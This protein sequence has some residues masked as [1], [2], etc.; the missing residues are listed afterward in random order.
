[1]KKSFIYFIFLLASLQGLTAYALPVLSS[2]PAAAATIYLDFDGETVNSSVWQS[3]NPFTCAPANMTD[4]QITE[5]FNRVAEDYRPFNIN[6]TTNLNVFLAA[7]YDERMRVI[8]TPTSAW[9]QGVG[10]VSYVGS[11][12]W[13]DDAPCFVFCDRL[14]PNSA[15][16]VAECCSHESGHTV[17]LSHQS[18]Y[19]ASCNLTA[20]YNAGAGAGQIGWAPIMG[21]SYGKNMS[22]WN[23]GPTPYGCK[24]VQD[25]LSIITTQNFFSYR[26]DDYAD[27]IN[28]NNNLIKI[29]QIPVEGIITTSA[30]KDVFKFNISTN[31]NLHINIDP[32]SVGINNA[33]ADLD[34]KVI[35]YNGNKTLLKVYDPIDKMNV[36]IDTILNAGNYYLEVQGAG[37]NNVSDY[38]SLGS[39]A[40]TGLQGM[41]PIHEVKLTGFINNNKTQLNW[42]ITS[43]EALSNITLE[44]SATADN[45]IAFTTLNVN[46]NSYAYTPLINCDRFYRLKVKSVQNQILYSNIVAVKANTFPVKSYNVSTIVHNT[47][48]INGPEAYQYQLSD[49]N[50]NII[51][52]GQ[53]QQGFNT[54]VVQQLIPAV[55]ILQL[56]NNN[57]KQTERIIK[58]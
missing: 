41:L 40:I 34:V 48:T 44:T 22:G 47:I 58:Q 30:D 10:G 3:G 13:G 32:F 45:F 46:S 56:I 9:Y 49:I 33:G 42:N 2:L 35:L 54:L 5:V 52:K 16:M 20:T 25:N 12:I 19:D 37:N 17:G 38:G 4:V 28:N 11:F 21:N 1:M 31:T 6:I 55:Y 7:P 53:G 24:D 23:N 8:I 36:V 50:G 26:T 39:Y 18:S 15:K 43:D 51:Y 57:Q 27:T 29:S 14:G